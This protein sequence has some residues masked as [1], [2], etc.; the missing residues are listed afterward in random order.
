MRN[1][2]NKEFTRKELYDLLNYSKIDKG[3][4]AVVCEGHNELSAYKIF[5]KDLDIT[6]MSDNK[7]KKINSLY[8][9]DLDYSTKILSTMSCEGDL[10]GYEMISDPDLKAY[11][12]WDLPFSNDEMLYYLKQTRMILDYMRS[13]GVIYADFDPR[14]ILYDRSSGLIMLCDMDNVEVDGC[15][16]DVVPWD[17]QEYHVTRGIDYGVHPYMHN[18]LLLR[19]MSE[20]VYSMDY[21][22]K[23]RKYFKRSGFRTLDSMLHPESFD[24][25]Y[26]IDHIKKL[27]R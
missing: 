18:S 19:V 15:P 2:P 10:I 24:N 9:L 11:K 8:Q 4:E 22:A 1:L 27:N 26:L 21:K 25:K 6:P 3:C 16:V 20:D 7:E 17:L 13:K 23:K 5:V 14:N 12:I